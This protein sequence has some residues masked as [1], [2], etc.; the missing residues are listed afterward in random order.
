MHLKYFNSAYLHRM[1]SPAG[2]L[3]TAVVALSYGI[4]AEFE[5]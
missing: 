1:K 2:L 4:A 3:I 5:G